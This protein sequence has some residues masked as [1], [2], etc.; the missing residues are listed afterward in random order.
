VLKTGMEEEQIVSYEFGSYQ[1]RPLERLLLRDGKPVVLTPKV[2]D[3][4][5]FFVQN[6][7]R[8]LKKDELLDKLW[9]DSI[10]EEGNLTQN[11]FMLRKILGENPRDHQYLVTI[12]L[13]G[14]KFVAR[15][16]KIYN[17]ET[18]E[19]F[20]RTDETEKGIIENP[21]TK[22]AVMPFTLLNAPVEEHFGGVGI[23]DTVITKLGRLR[24]IVLRPTT[25]VLKYVGAKEDLSAIGRELKVDAVL[26]GT[27]Q[28]LGN[29]IRVNVR[30]VR[31]SNGATLWANDFN[32]DSTDFFAVQDS[33]SRQVVQALRLELNGEEQQQLVKNYTENLEAH[34]LYIK[35]R[36]FW[37]RRN[38]E[39][40]KKGI[41]YVNK[42][43]AID[44]NYALAYLGLADSYLFLGQYLFL[45]PQEAF[46][47][48]RDYA[49][50]VLELDATLTEA[51]ASL[52]EVALFYEWDWAK[53]EVYYKSAIET[54]PNYS[55][56]LHWYAWFLM[57]QGRF[58]EAMAKIKQAQNLD[59]GSLTLNT[60]L[61][62]PFYYQRQYDRAIE[63]FRQTLEMEPHFAQASYYLGSALTKKGLYD[64]AIAEL[65]KNPKA[66][67][68]LQTTALLAYNYALAGKKSK[69]L[70]A[71]NELKQLAEQRYVS[72][73]LEAIIYT[74]LGDRTQA[75]AQLERGCLERAAWMVFLNVDPLLDSL[76]NDPRFSDV[77]RAVGFPP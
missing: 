29:R 77:Q 24:G 12:P 53:A 11:I 44:P 21:V 75:F 57:T 3:T 68:G 20:S 48:A 19:D 60:V 27:I 72:P 6:N 35:G 38:E 4:L 5:L 13:Q 49:L 66:E 63:Q 31:V 10:V 28:Q 34:Q 7:G 2:F 16:R 62:L 22:I 58:D 64:E 40:L 59:P 15:V 39:G 43:I 54:N 70:K 45:H 65:R 30:L 9:A 14:Y 71:L 36:Y 18:G 46:P 23:T 52:A 25:A 73:Y 32:E 51:H 26:D 69:A 50:K 41:D 56:G 47:K 33:I 1:V 37:D 17:E 55:S 42:V 67:Y 74:G 61:G 8:L 76:R